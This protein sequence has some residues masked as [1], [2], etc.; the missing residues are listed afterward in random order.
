[1]TL[2]AFDLYGTLLDFRGLA[3]PALLDAWRQAQLER[4]WEL[5]QLGRFEPFDRV[6]RRALEKVAPG[7]DA[8]AADRLCAAW[9]SLP[10]FPEAAATLR[11]LRDAGARTAI[12][13]NGT[14]AMIEAAL[15]AAGL[16]VDEVLSVERVG[17]YKPDPRV[18]ALVPRDGTLFV[19]ANPFD[20]DGAR[21]AGLTVCAIDRARGETLDKVVLA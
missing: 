10:P 16:V 1:L 21:R 9:L 17:V 5:N 3:D 18:Y 4:T 7:L 15:A 12:L 14:A 8:G 13:S 6:T 2:V 19:S 11:R 20:A